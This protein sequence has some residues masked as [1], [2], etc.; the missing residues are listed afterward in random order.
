MSVAYKK[1]RTFLQ[2]EMRMSHIY[3]PL[4]IKTILAG[5]GR[6]ST[7]QIAAAFLAEDESQLEYYEAITNRM[8]GPVLRRRGIV[9]RD[10][11]GYTLADHSRELS[12]DEREN[13]IGLCDEAIAAYKKKRGRAVW[14]HRAVGLGRI[15]GK[16]RYETLKRAGFRCELCGVSADERALDVDHIVPRRAGGLDESENFQALCWKCNTNKGAGDE[17]DFRA[18]RAAHGVREE[19]CPFC[20]LAEGALVGAN[21]LA[22]AV[23]D[24]YP[25]TPL[26]TLIISRRHVKDFFQ[27]FASEHRA[28]AVLADQIRRQIVEMDSTVEGFNVGVNSAEVA[29]QTIPHCHVHVIPRRAGDVANPRGG[30][31]WVIPEKGDYRP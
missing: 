15:P 20:S 30:V 26:H 21:A 27:L 3:Q 6:A 8:P 23:R 24:R 18:V 7:R 10:G 4:M 11:D 5:Q 28:V 9:I 19:G 29:G 25:V 13:L 22:V 12:D 14:E 31:R 17:T 1:L 2:D 16:L